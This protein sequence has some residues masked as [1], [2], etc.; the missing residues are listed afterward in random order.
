MT[1]VILGIQMTLRLKDLALPLI[2]KDSIMIFKTL[3]Y[4]P[5]QKL[6]SSQQ[7]KERRSHKKGSLK[8]V[9]IS[10]KNKKN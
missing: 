10:Y 6:E 4:F 3:S 5:F 1:Q 7:I 8:E 9:I 2:L